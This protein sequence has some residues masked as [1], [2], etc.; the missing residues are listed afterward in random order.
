MISNAHFTQECMAGH[1]KYSFDWE[2]EIF[3]AD[4]K[5]I[6]RISMSWVATPKG[7]GISER[8]EEPNIQKNFDKH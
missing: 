2:S 4:L 5:T 6:I 7:Q 1:F 3:T 8:L